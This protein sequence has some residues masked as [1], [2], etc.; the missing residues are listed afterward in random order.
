MCMKFLTVRGNVFSSKILLL[1]FI[2]VGVIIIFWSIQDRDVIGFFLGIM[3]LGITYLGTFFYIIE[4][5][6]NDVFIINYK[7]EIRHKRKDI[8]SVTP[9]K[10]Y[11]NMYYLN[12][13]NGEK[14][15]FTFGSQKALFIE[16]AASNA[17]YLERII[18]TY[19]EDN[20]LK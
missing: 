7:G 16:D 12:F 9:F 18:T 19:G 4:Y 17:K 5:N 15:L 1:I 8:L 6:E 14:Y 20:I 3:S 13:I 2:I 10:P 11:L